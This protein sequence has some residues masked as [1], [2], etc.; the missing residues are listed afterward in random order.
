MGSVKLMLFFQQGLDLNIILIKPVLMVSGCQAEHLEGSRVNRCL[1]RVP[2]IAGSLVQ[3]TSE[4]GSELL[5]YRW[6][7]QLAGVKSC[8]NFL[9]LGSSHGLNMQLCLGDDETVVCPTVCTAHCLGH[10]HVL[11]VLSPDKPAPP[12]LRIPAPL[13]RRL[14]PAPLL[15]PAAA[16]FPGL[17]CLAGALRLKVPPATTVPTS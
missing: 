13:P 12:L 5:L 3:L 2:V 17:Q 10:S 4:G 9:S 1:Q 15:R 8:R 6:L 11:P 7:F 14:A 16:S